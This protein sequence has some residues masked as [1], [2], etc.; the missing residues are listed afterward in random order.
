MKTNTKKNILY[1]D[2]DFSSSGRDTA[3]EHIETETQELLT[4]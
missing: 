4:F 2:V 1:L 3:E